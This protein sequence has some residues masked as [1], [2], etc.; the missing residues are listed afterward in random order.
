MQNEVNKA[1]QTLKSGGVILFP[2]DIGWSLGCNASNEDAIKKMLS[3]KKTKNTNLL[4]CLVADD[5]MIKKYIREIP[6]AAQSIIDATDKPTTI[7]YDEAKNLP[8]VLIAKD[9]TVA[10]RIPDNEL[11]Y[12]LCRRLNGAIA[13][14]SA[15]VIE[16]TTPKSYKEIAP[17]VL[18]GVD[19]IVNLHKDKVYVKST[20]SIIKLSNSGIVKIIKA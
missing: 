16:K 11:C 7:I 8:S 3:I 14:I 17:E 18:K 12:W 2:S 19:Y 5:R 4:T 13:H 20:P 10:I 9:K 1:L 6:F 15:N